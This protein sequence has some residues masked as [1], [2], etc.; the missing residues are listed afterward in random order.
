MKSKV[1][2]NIKRL[3]YEI[4]SPQPIPLH[5]QFPTI[6]LRGAFGYSLIQLV[7]RDQSIGDLKKVDICKH[8]FFA[9]GISQKSLHHNCA[10]PFVMRGGYSRPDKKSFLLEMLIFGKISQH[11]PL[12]D[13]VIMNMCEMGLGKK[14]VI[15][16]CKKIF[17]EDIL[18]QI[19]DLSSGVCLVNFQTPTR[20]K[21]QGR[22]LAEGIPFSN[23]F[24]GVASRLGELVNVYGKTKTDLDLED[25]KGFAKTVDTQVNCGKYFEVK[26]CS[27]RTGDECRL[28]GF[29]GSIAYRGVLQPF[30][31][32]L[33]YLPWINVGS[34]T[35]FGC[36]WC[37]LEYQQ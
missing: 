7:A 21:K 8:L 5:A 18:P 35:A 23:L 29:V 19:P 26:R 1:K 10:R 6:T 14:N 25:L 22:Y 2:L 13:D 11:E 34:S 4:N 15:C 20:I 12:I 30:Q 36:G 16:R 37:T 27:T 28:N 24:S 32:V 3:L 31:E 33:S 17:S 9:D